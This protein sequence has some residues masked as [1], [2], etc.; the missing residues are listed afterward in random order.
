[1]LVPSQR[2]LKSA[3]P[4]LFIVGAADVLS[5]GADRSVREVGSLP[6]PRDAVRV[7]EEVQADCVCVWCTGVCW[8][9][10]AEVVQAEQHIGL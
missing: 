4:K 2:P 6:Q 5:G 8:C 3:K 9:V 7:A 10:R 1:M